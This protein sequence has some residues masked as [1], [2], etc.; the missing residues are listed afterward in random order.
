M[1]GS[2]IRR[3]N[4]FQYP[5]GWAVDRILS[6][7]N[8]TA[9]RNKG[10][11]GGRSPHRG[12]ARPPLKGTVYSIFFGSCLRVIVNS[13]CNHTSSGMCTKQF[14]YISQQQRQPGRG[15]KQ[16]SAFKNKTTFTQQRGARTKILYCCKR[17]YGGTMLISPIFQNYFYLITI[18][19]FTGR[20]YGR[21][22][23]P[24]TGKSRNQSQ[25]S[26]EITP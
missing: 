8:C 26:M 15:V 6:G 18:L 1:R 9:G 23:L 7:K 13:N 4:Q 11:T 12:A 20:F 10:W 14:Q 25:T 17:G 22:H 5:R 24:K 3:R 21:R 19:L 16:A 2:I